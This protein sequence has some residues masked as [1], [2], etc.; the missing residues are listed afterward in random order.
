MSEK[1]KEILKFI[2]ENDEVV[3]G[4]L[5]K[6]FPSGTLSKYLRILVAKEFVG[7]KHNDAGKDVYYIRKIAEVKKLIHS[8]SPAQL[9]EMKKVFDKIL[10][11]E[12]VS[13][14]DMQELS[15]LLQE[16]RE[17]K[18]KEQ[19]VESFK[20]EQELHAEVEKENK[21]FFKPKK[22]ASQ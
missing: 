21:E 13:L 9:R 10:D 8:L 18:Y 22:K 5:L 20:M 12:D 2:Y 11:F 14:E 17:K 6:I 4:Q 7:K 16:W 3:W 1:E 15:D 19:Q